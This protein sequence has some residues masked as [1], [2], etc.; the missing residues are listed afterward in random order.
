MLVATQAQLDLEGKYR[1]LFI[2]DYKIWTACFPPSFWKKEKN[3]NRFV[4]GLLGRRAFT[5]P[6]SIERLS[7]SFSVWF[8]SWRTDISTLEEGAAPSLLTL[9][10]F[11][12]KSQPCLLG[13]KVTTRSWHHFFGLTARSSEKFLKF[14]SCDPWK[15]W[16]MKRE[17]WDRERVFHLLSALTFM[18]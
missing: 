1:I 12:E 9:F 13:E 7:L 14:G 8:R 6:Q 11:F 4:V 18:L 15:D 3:V 17:K 10:H 2:S 16:K 5:S